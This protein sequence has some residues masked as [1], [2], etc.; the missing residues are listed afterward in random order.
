MSLGSNARAALFVLIALAI[1]VVYLLGHTTTGRPKRDFIRLLEHHGGARW[2]T[3]EINLPGRI[4]E[5]LTRTG[6]QV[7][8]E[9]MH[10]SCTHYL[11]FRGFAVETWLCRTRYPVHTTDLQPLVHRA[12]GPAGG[13]VWKDGSEIQYMQRNTLNP[14]GWFPIKQGIVV[15]AAR[16]EG[17]TSPEATYTASYPVDPTYLARLNRQYWDQDPASFVFRNLE[18]D[19][20]L[21]P[22]FFAPAPAEITFKVELPAD[23]HLLF[24]FGILE[25]GWF[26]SD[27]VEFSVSVVRGGKEEAVFSRILQ[28]QSDPRA[29]RWRDARVDLSRY[30]GEYVELI[31]RTGPGMQDNRNFD[32][33]A[34]SSPIL[35][36]PTGTGIATPIVIIDIDT[37]RADHLQ[38]YG[39]GQPTSPAINEFAEESVVFERA[40]AQAPWT[41]PSQMSILTGLYPGTHQVQQP[42][43]R[44]VPGVPTLASQLSRRG[45]F[46]KA[47]TDGGAI[48][49]AFGFDHGFDS[50]SEWTGHH[51]ADYLTGFMER[52]SEWLTS[53][54]E[55]NFFL[56]LHT[57]Q[58]HAAY[59]PPDEYWQLFDNDYAGD[60]FQRFPP[61]GGDFGNVSERDVQHLVARYDGGIRYVDRA[62]GD[63]LALL[64]RQG[65]YDRALIVFLSDHG[66]EFRD[67]GGWLHQSTLYDEMLRVPLVIK[68]PK[69]AI[70]PK[71]V[72]RQIETVDLLPTI[73]D[74]LGVPL[75]EGLDGSSRMVLI[76]GDDGA[77]ASG[78][79]QFAFSEL[80]G[81]VSV[82]TE[83]HKLIGSRSGRRFFS[84][85]EDPGEH[86]SLYDASD[87][88]VREFEAA[89]ADY[90]RKASD[91]ER[92]AATPRT[93]LDAS[94]KRQ[95]EML[96]YGDQP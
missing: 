11:G 30:S 44:L 67:H 4:I 87:P 14:D 66:E 80:D 9:E 71:R 93:P 15:T 68:F 37:L 3:S 70:A 62:V 25:E 26:D 84:L 13:R 46:T 33:A 8:R 28:P 7:S 18:I 91:H 90:A 64:R 45:Y 52:A 73:L 89:L 88:L 76:R 96:G 39:Y 95:L 77:P 82:R 74:F 48:S 94:T 16:R 23:A 50:Y 1:G 38:L 19:G 41:L 2:T 59:A 60:I 75:P 53:F 17:A 78:A 49:S 6:F 86:R 57:Y 32:F 63:L 43:Q 51:G 20:D 55:S 40:I 34:F 58:C 83:T 12:S 65:L 24:G 85:A 42:N 31:F 69:G 27:G 21:R 47:V 54:P 92:R 56:L 22:A 79:K 5:E 72:A 61:W 10:G 35:Y 36:R 29:G 81:A